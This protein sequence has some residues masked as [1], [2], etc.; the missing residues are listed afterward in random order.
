MKLFFLRYTLPLNQKWIM[1]A[2]TMYLAPLYISVIYISE[3]NET[4]II[5]DTA[6]QLA[7]YYRYSCIDVTPFTYSLR[8]QWQKQTIP[9]LTSIHIQINLT[10]CFS[11]FKKCFLFEK[12]FFRILDRF[13]GL[14]RLFSHLF[15]F[16]PKPLDLCLHIDRSWEMYIHNHLLW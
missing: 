12:I 9:K 14:L 3:S 5:F 15:I 4:W 13:F 8:S 6:M 16:S 2:Q 7:V 1:Y 10:F 11:V